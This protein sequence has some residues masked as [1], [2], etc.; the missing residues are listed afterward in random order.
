V[1]V[2]T[3]TRELGS[4]DVRTRQANAGVQRPRECN[5]VR[6]PRSVCTPGLTLSKVTTA[7]FRPETHTR[8]L[9]QQ[10]SKP[11]LKSNDP[12]LAPEH[13]TQYPGH[14]EHRDGEPSPGSTVTV[15]GS[16]DEGSRHMVRTA[17]AAFVPTDA[18]SGGGTGVMLNRFPS[19]S[20]SPTPVL[21]PRP[22]TRQALAA[23]ACEC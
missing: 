13:S 20:R 14:S 7:T 1:A 4:R 17:G 2:P 18:F 16:H 23:R 12:R 8:Q 21:P 19:R 5:S 22:E 9:V 15:P 10:A 6:R 3:Q 11:T